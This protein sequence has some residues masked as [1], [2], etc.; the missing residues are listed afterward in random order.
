MLTK[1]CFHLWR[2]EK[3]FA[4]ILKKFFIYKIFKFFSDFLGHLG[5][6]LIRENSLIRK[7]KWSLNVITSQTGRLQHTYWPTSLEV[8]AASDTQTVHRKGEVYSEK[9]T[10]KVC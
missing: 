5:K 7:L 1:M 6:G 8:K 3:W 10:N 9:I 2:T 4:L